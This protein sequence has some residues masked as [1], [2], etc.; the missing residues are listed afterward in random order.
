MNYPKTYAIFIGRFQPFHLGH[1]S[2]IDRALKDFDSIIIVIGSDNEPRSTRNPFTSEERENMISLSFKNEDMK[3]IKFIR[4]EDI[5]YNDNLW[6]AEVISKVEKIINSDKDLKDNVPFIHLI[7]YRKD[8]T[9]YYLKKFPKWCSKGY[10][11][12]PEFIELNSTYI[13]HMYFNVHSKFIEESRSIVSDATRSFL[14]TFKFKD[15]Y[16]SICKE[17][18]FLKHHADM[19]KGAPYTPT[20]N[21]VDA[22]VV[23]SGHVLM[24]RRRAEP[25]KGLLAL[26]GGYLD[27]HETHEDS[28]IREL[29]E[30][31][32]IDVPEKLLR[33][34]IKSHRSFAAPNRS[35]RGRIITEAFLIELPDQIYLPKVKGS[36]DA[37]KALWIPIKN[38][39]RKLIFEDH[40]DIIMRTIS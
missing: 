5:R 21:T 16:Q 36:D 25:G 11:P 12:L 15:E 4:Q 33:G 38:L 7:G 37:D 30:E 14:D 19:W 34:L 40:L 32:K 23:Q 26:P 29:K 6:T 18:G 27:V 24:I 35:E 13:R 9:S 3:R 31:T 8:Y 22:V 20:F 17:Y 39:D 10:D 28:M 2:I 1:K